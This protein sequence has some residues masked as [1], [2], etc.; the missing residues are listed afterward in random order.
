MIQNLGGRG[1]SV[2]LSGVVFSVEFGGKEPVMHEVVQD[3][4]ISSES[5]ARPYS[6]VG[7]GPSAVVGVDAISVD[8]MSA[9]GA[10]VLAMDVAADDWATVV[11]SLGLVVTGVTCTVGGYQYTST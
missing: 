4:G 11:P 3:A 8:G 9:D 7:R 10:M 5:L 1:D 6:E 2:S